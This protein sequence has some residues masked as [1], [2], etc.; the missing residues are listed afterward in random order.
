MKD[1]KGGWQETITQ[2]KEA[3]GISLLTKKQASA[4][5]RLYI[6]GMCTEEIIKQMKGE[7]EWKVL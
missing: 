2:V 1:T 3:L 5:L 4:M 6:T 7:K